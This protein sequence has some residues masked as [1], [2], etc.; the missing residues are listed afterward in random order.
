[1]KYPHNRMKESVYS[2]SI[3]LK[4]I[5]YWYLVS[6]F[7]SLPPS[8]S[9]FGLD[10]NKLLTSYKTRRW[11]PQ[12]PHDLII[13]TWGRYLGPTLELVRCRAG[14]CPASASIP[15]AAPMLSLTLIV[16]NCQIVWRSYICVKTL[17]HV[18]ICGLGSPLSQFQYFLLIIHDFCFEACMCSYG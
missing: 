13:R 15:S 4:P 3:S 17:F 8:L 9:S 6:M 16:W 10:E 1:M 5:S 2:F 11:V 12:A 14:T 18:W 7:L